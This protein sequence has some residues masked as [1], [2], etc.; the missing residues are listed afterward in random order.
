M[1]HLARL[2]SLGT[3]EYAPLCGEPAPAQMST[4]TDLVDCPFCRSAF[5]SPSTGQTES[6]ARV[7]KEQRRAKRRASR[8]S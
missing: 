4:N 3:A 2:S 7:R 8:R 5:E 1:I 6:D